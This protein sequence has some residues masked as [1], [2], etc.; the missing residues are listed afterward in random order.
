MSRSAHAFA[1]SQDKRISRSQLGITI[2]AIRNVAFAVFAENTLGAEFNDIFRAQLVAE[3]EESDK[4]VR[5]C[6]K[7]EAS[8]L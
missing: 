1:T 3:R 4:N 5:I 6:S 8:S 2:K 7:Q